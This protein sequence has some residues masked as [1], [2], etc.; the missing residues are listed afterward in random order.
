M[1]K[2]E[3]GSDMLMTWLNLC[4]LNGSDDD[5]STQNAGFMDFVHRPEF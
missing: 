3:C 2:Y 1:I 4:N 5:I